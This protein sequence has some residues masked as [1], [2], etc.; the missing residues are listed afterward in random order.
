MK[1]DFLHYI[2]K[3]KKFKINNL[4]TTDGLAV[5]LVSV[6]QHNHNSGPDFFNAK[7]RINEQLWAGNVEIHL[8]SSD[9][10]LHGHEK[11]PNYDNVILHVVWEDDSEIFRKDNSKL[12]TLKLKNYI[13][14]DVISNYKNL[15]VRSGKWINC[16]NQ[17]DDVDEFTITKWLEQ[18]YFERLEDKSEFIYQILS[19]SNNNWEEVL[20]KML[21]R[22]FGLK[23]NGEAFFSLA[24][25]IDFKLIRKLRENK[26]GLEA[27]LFGQ[28]NLLVNS[29]EDNF[30]KQLKHEYDYLKRKYSLTTEGVLPIQFFRL[31][32][33]N[34][35]TIRLSQF[36]S[37]YHNNSSLFQ[38]V[39]EIN[40][41]EDYHKLFSVGV[42]EYWES[43]YVFDRTSRKSKKLLTSSFIDLLI[44]NTIIPLKFAYFKFLG[45]KPKEELIEI[46]EQIK[47]EKNNIVDRFSSLGISFKSA[48]DSQAIIQLKRS[49]CNQNKCLNCQFG[50]A[51]L[52][53]D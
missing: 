13:L 47:P 32:P 1:E 17:L 41:L 36:T 45:K 43:H 10:Y 40:S 8:K 4:K 6:G 49:Y 33:F 18:L 28:G 34:F 39:I 29:F 42:S 9:W 22:N 31:R 3:F 5:Q 35:P 50:N 52:I 2:W 19:S 24:T 27:I 25:N 30:Y 16:E 46:I 15:F 51:I 38:N 53:R 21:L 20:Y 37:L 48:M 23:V 11:D 26:I 7:I 44:I 12:S 14:K